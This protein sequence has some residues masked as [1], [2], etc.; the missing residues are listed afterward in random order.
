MG[1]LYEIANLNIGDITIG[2]LQDLNEKGFYPVVRAGEL[3]GF[4]NEDGVKYA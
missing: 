2:E 4:E 3:I 1:I